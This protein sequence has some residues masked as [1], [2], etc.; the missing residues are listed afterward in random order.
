MFN[1]ILAHSAT[2][3]LPFRGVCSENNESQTSRYIQV[4]ILVL[5]KNKAGNFL[6]NVLNRLHSVLAA[7][8]LS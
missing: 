1:E 7:L 8:S 3:A 6:I 4:I 2:S 5:H